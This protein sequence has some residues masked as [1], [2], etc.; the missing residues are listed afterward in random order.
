MI[1]FSKTPMRISFFGGGTDYPIYFKEFPGAVLG[2]AIN[3]H[4]YIIALPMAGLAQ[5]RFRFLY[6]K[7]ET[8]DR[9]EDIEHAVIRSVLAEEKFESTLNLAVLS[10]IPGGTGLG[11]SSTFTVGMLNL[12]NAFKNVQ[13]S[14]YA[15]AKRAI[16]IEHDVL[17]ENVGIQ[18]QLYAAYGGLTAFNF[19][20]DDLSIRP[21]Q[22]THE[23]QKA[24]DDSMFLI[25]T[26][27]FR[28][29]TRTVEEQLNR[30]KE[31]QV[32]RELS[33]LVELVKAG[34]QALECG[35]PETML[36]DLGK[37]L[38]DAWETKKKLAETISN[39]KVDSIYEK[40]M[41]LGA[42][43]GKLLGAGAGGFVLVL[44]PSHLHKQY[45]EVFGRENIVKISC[46]PNGSRVRTFWDGSCPL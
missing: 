27:I 38:S 9:I 3:K 33:H 37:L 45:N 20:G 42:Y 23:C 1:R 31:K 44:A 7:I 28:S 21:I 30:T 15:L 39:P 6:S 11:S 29:A 10:D 46:D 2:T 26:G 5:T 4:I 24:L 14:R 41:E 35:V 19:H 12:V 18:D 40:A 16:H 22:I 34:Q 43:G 17:R 8:V 13:L 25:F 32:L 36:K